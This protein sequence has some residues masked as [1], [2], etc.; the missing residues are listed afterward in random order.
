MPAPQLY[1]LTINLHMHTTYSDGSGSHAQIAQAA[2]RCGLDAIIITDHNVWVDGPEDYYRLGDRRVL[3]MVGEEVHDQ[4]RDPQKNHLLIFG[5]RQELAP[6][7]HDPQRLLDGVAKAG[8]LAF[9][10]HPV[11]PAAPAVGE[12]DLSWETWDVSGYTGIELWNGFSEF[13]TLLKSKLHALYYIMYP[14][15]INRGPLPEALA[16]WDALLAAGK[17]VV[18]VGGSDAHQST[19]RLGPLRLTIFPYEFHFQTVNTHVLVPRPL[20]EDAVEDSR[21]ILDALGDGHTFV[22]FDLPASTAGF[23]FIAQG[24]EGMVVMGDEIS[25]EGGV[26]FQIRLPLRT[27][28]RLLKDGKVI[29][30][31]GN[32]DFCTHIT[33][34]PGV[35]RVEAYLDYLG[36]RRGWIFS[37]PIYVR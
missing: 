28:C 10:A 32:R 14:R 1:E 22:G 15:R 35:Y 19:R 30:K 7:A 8:G 29:K 2:L 11:D 37:N 9:L 6:L 5:A 26:T 4:A 36:I 13:K 31:W 16:R 24:K 23:R 34:E 21:M 3:L 20:K 17:R 18:A 27:E 33:T 12:D 25:A